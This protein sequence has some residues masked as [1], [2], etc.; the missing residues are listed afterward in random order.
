MHGGT[1]DL[2]SKL[3]EGTEVT[4]TIP[5]SRVLEVMPRLDERPDRKVVSR[6]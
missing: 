4:V 1:F 5:H 6:R 3:R 2:R